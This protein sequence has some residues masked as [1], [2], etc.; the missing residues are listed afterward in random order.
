MI[1]NP[2]FQVPTKGGNGKRDLWDKFVHLCLNYLVNDNGHLALIHP[3]KWRKPE[4]KLFNEIKKHWLKYL[5]IHNDQDGK[6]TFG[7]TTRYDWYVLQKNS[8]G[9]TKIKDELGHLEEIGISD[10][11]FLS[12]YLISEVTNILANNNEDKCELI[13]SSSIY[14]GRKSYMSETKD[15]NHI[16]PCIY[17]MYKNGTHKYL[18]SSQNKGHFGVSKVII[19]YGRYPYPFIDI[20]GEYGMC[21]NAFAIKVDDI[22]EA[23][24]IKRAIESDRF[25]NILKATKWGNFQIEYKMFKYFRKDFWKEFV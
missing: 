22:K 1:G 2:P 6:K 25:K 15:N 10:V 7:A 14:D 24:N 5:E 18:Y 8:T 13:Y 4:H 23:N 20:N 21:N 3:A 12:N 19:S 9:K 17:G 11:S 16:Y